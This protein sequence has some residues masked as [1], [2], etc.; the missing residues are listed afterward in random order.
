M[1][2]L[3]VG[4][5]VIHLAYAYELGCKETA[6][7]ALSLACTEFSGFNQLVDH[8][9]PEAA[10]YRTKSLGEILDRVRQDTRFDGVA[11]YPGITNMGP[12]MQNC[13][14]A[15][16]EH[17]N[18]WEINDPLQQLEQL[19]DLSTL[20]ALTTCDAVKEFDFYLLHLMTVAHGLRVLWHLFPLD[21]QA[22]MLREF[23]VFAITQFVCQQR[24]A[25]GIEDIE[26]VDV[27]GRDWDWVRK[28]ATNHPG[29]FDVH[30]FKAVRAPIAFKD[31]FGEKDGFYL[32]A[33]VKFLDEYRGWTGF[34]K[35]LDGFD[36][37]TEQWYPKH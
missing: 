33:A 25:F 15:V 6:S 29:R 37:R 36:P 9:Q 26:A 19:C 3:V 14:G 24:P 18:A 22:P 20:V 28:T 2:T 12:L 13:G 27:K 7:E 30:F 11:E 23:A 17:W 1:L 16:I 32:K 31:T 10:A 21:R 8:P 4:H 34:G 5:P 35:G